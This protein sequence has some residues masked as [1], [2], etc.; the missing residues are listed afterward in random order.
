MVLEN[1][2]TNPTKSLWKFS[3]GG[4]GDKKENKLLKGTIKTN[5]NFQRG[6][7]GSGGGRVWPK[8]SF[9]GPVGTFLET[10]K[11]SSLKVMTLILEQKGKVH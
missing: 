6:G 10:K 8:K 1:V 9:M 3:G 11:N 7:G 2:H 4:E 5:W